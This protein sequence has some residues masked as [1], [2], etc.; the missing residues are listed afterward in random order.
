MKLYCSPL[1]CPNSSG[2]DR[3]R[4]PDIALSTQNH[5]VRKALFLFSVFLPISKSMSQVIRV[6]LSHHPR[7]ANH[8]FL[9]KREKT[10][11][12]LIVPG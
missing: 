6:F 12:L 5:I 8:F 9:T 10:M 1:K 4:D 3:R 7:Q 2:D 11:N